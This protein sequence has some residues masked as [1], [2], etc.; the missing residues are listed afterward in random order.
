MQE[1]A[2]K[3]GPPSRHRQ[4]PQVNR[5]GVHPHVGKTRPDSSQRNRDALRENVRNVQAEKHQPAEAHIKERKAKR[6]KKVA[7]PNEE[8]A[9]GEKRSDEESECDSIPNRP[10]KIFENTGTEVLQI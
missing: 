2:D 6:Q 8:D 7:F 4:V 1:P 3:A 10:Q 9:A 5:I